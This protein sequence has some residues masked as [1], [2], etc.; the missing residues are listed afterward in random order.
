MDE[1]STPKYMISSWHMLLLKNYKYLIL[2]TCYLHNLVKANAFLGANWY[3]VIE[4]WE[5]QGLC[6]PTMK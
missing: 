4:V 1:L 6:D 5:K 2:L 3:C